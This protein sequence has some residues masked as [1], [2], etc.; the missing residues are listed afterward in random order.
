MPL[1]KVWNIQEGMWK[2]WERLRHLSGC[3]NY[4]NSVSLTPDERAKMVIEDYNAL[5]NRRPEPSLTI[6]EYLKQ[7]Q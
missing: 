3:R 4:E 7:N 5:D 1:N 2:H 6:E